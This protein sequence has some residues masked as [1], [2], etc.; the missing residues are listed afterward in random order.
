M[1]GGRCLN[2]RVVIGLEAQEVGADGYV[3]IRATSV[4][5]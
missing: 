4:Q 5:A 1:R 2:V 3:K